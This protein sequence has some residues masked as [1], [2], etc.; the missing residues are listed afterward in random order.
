MVQK[1][2]TRYSA[3]WYPSSNLLRVST[4]TGVGSCWG[5]CVGGT[6]VELPDLCFGASI[7]PGVPWVLLAT[8]EASMVIGTLVTLAPCAP[9]VEVKA[10]PPRD[11]GRFL[12]VVP[13][14]HALS[15]HP[16]VGFSFEVRPQREPWAMGILTLL[17]EPN[18]IEI[19]VPST[20]IQRPLIHDGLDLAGIGEEPLNIIRMFLDVNPHKDIECHTPFVSCQGPAFLCCYGI[21]VRL[22]IVGFSFTRVQNVKHV[23]KFMLPDFLLQ[24]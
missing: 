18:I 23:D 9:G 17:P 19:P 11:W 21:Y 1:P 7:A 20:L 12:F 6:V 15:P 8:L 3:S 13:K 16:T 4:L 24:L 14:G 5:V 10:V 2:C 22:D